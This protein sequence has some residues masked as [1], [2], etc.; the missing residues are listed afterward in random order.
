MTPAD[1]ENLNK[2]PFNIYS[3]YQP[4]KLIKV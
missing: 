2:T 4:N 1:Q 3:Y